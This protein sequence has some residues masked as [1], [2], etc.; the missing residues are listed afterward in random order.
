[1][2][3][4][5]VEALRL[6]GK[7]LPLFFDRIDGL[8]R[9]QFPASDNVLYSLTRWLNSAC[10]RWLFEKGGRSEWYCHHAF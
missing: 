6:A 1:M 8:L 7:D 4:R 10:P 3:D 2:A 9:E 5:S